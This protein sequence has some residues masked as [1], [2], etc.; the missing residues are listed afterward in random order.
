MKNIAIFCDGTWQNLGQR[1]PTNVTRLARAVLPTDTEQDAKR[2]QVVYYDDGVGVGQG[3][4]D[5]AQRLIGGAFG[6]GLDYKIGRAYE[7]LCLN[8]APGDRVF[9][10]G[11]SRG[12]YTARSLVGLLRRVWILKRENVGLLDTA[13]GIYRN[14]SAD[15]VET[16]LFRRSNCHD[17]EPFRAPREANPLTVAQAHVEAD[18]GAVQYVGVWDTVGSLGVPTTLPF[19]KHLNDKY[20]FHDESLSRFVLSARH[21]VAID[22]RRETFVPALWDNIAKLNANASAAELQYD[23][24]PYLQAWFPGHH[25]SVGGGEDDGGVSIPPLLWIANGAQRAGLAFDPDLLAIYDHAADAAADFPKVPRSIG[26]FIKELP[27]LSPRLGPDLAEDV[28]DAAVQ[29]WTRRPDYR[30]EPIERWAAEI[31]RRGNV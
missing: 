23:E 24:R 19:A 9:V 14:H 20:R 6:E 22:E 13:I 26:D 3:V 12:A 28:S 1:F 18:I 17:C 7:F 30:P 4:L 16:I 5:D 31:E 8:Y 10:F 21:A 25:S 11:F 29:R 15:A 27:G 2:E